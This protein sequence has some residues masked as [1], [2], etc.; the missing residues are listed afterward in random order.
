M[1]AG[2]AVTLVCLLPYTCGYGCPQRIV[3]EV[4]FLGER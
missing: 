4:E 1:L 3:L 2:V